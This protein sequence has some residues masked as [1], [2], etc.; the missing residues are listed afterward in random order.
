MNFFLNRLN[1]LLE[2]QDLPTAMLAL[3]DQYGLS[4]A[5]LALVLAAFLKSN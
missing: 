5:T 1:S 3:A 4:K 2:T